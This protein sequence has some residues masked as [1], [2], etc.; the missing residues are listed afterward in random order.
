MCINNRL[1]KTLF[2]LLL[3][4]IYMEAFAQ[5][6]RMLFTLDRE[7][8]FKPAPDEFERIAVALNESLFMQI[9][10]SGE[11]LRLP[12]GESEV[13][14]RVLGVQEYFPGV[15]SFF[16]EDVYQQGRF[17]AL[18]YTSDSFSGVMQLL[19]ESEIYHF[20]GNSDSG[21]GIMARM[22]PDALD[23]LYC[24]DEQD[25]RSIHSILHSQHHGMSKSNGGLVESPQLF[26]S[27]GESNVV[28]TPDVR[29]TID[30]MIVYTPAAENWANTSG[31]VVN[32]ETAIAQAM[33]LSQQALT[34]SN[35][36]IDLRL[37]HT[38]K[39]NYDENG[40]PSGTT[41]RRLTSSPSVNL[42]NDFQGYMDEV[43][44][45]RDQYGAD[46]VAMLS[47]I[48]DTGGIA[49]RIGAYGGSSHLGFSVNR[50]Q[51]THRTYTL[52]HEIGHN[53]GLSHGRNQNQAA[54]VNFGGIHDYSTG[55][56]FSNVFNQFYNTVM[57]YT[58]SNSTDY[59]GFSDPSATFD[60]GATGEANFT[61]FGP[62]NNARS[63]R[64]MK[65]QIARYR[66]PQV[67]PPV[68]GV[69][70]QQLSATVPRGQTGSITLNISNTGAGDLVWSAETAPMPVLTKAIDNE[71]LMNLP[72]GEVIYQT[73]F[74]SSEGFTVGYSDM[75]RSWRTFNSNHRFQISN[76]N[77][78]SGSQHLR[79]PPQIASIEVNTGITAETPLLDR[80]QVGAYSVTFDISTNQSGTSLYWIYFQDASRGAVAG[81]VT[82]QQGRVFV[83][84][85]NAEGQ[86]VYTSPTGYTLPANT[87]RKI[88][89]ISNIETGKISYQLDNLPPFE[90]NIYGGVAVDFFTVSKRYTGSET[91]Y[92][93]IDNLKITRHFS[94][95]SWLDFTATS[96]HVTPSSSSNLEIVF[97]ARDKA[98]GEY[99]GTVLIRTNDANNSLIQVPVRLTVVDG[100]GIE[101]ID[102]LP[103]ATSLDQNYPNPFNPSTVIRYQLAEPGLTRLAVYDL[104][105]RQIALLI[106][107][108]RPA[109]SHEVI[110][111]AESLSSGVYLYRLET[112]NGAISRKMILTK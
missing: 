60:G 29:Q 35:V 74:E 44:T 3:S 24:G 77:P 16:A 92:L 98:I 63:I 4:F 2:V 80:G 14:F 36:G 59:P 32:L 70:T 100:T 58:V 101:T 65:G 1:F 108:D 43:H 22:R 90:T 20:T 11:I 86:L 5:Q 26:S 91:D 111:N 93:D 48:E 87:Y 67:N 34:Q 62:A 56:L 99:S 73:D 52:I 37:V 112:P 79:M 88:T 33:N 61:Q 94:G 25:E 78:A 47:F 8:A 82:V 46:L 57:N 54:A 96:G 27:A 76:A 71:S 30:V 23:Q 18:T 103:V 109:G 42:G 104:L 97:D 64:D 15:F 75:M 40:V 7:V 21:P 41:L 13:D 72:E 84:N 55:W 102:D 68:A 50:I 110:F 39:V 105:G 45:L 66:L 10:E 31:Q 38:Y 12:V 81:E 107:E 95:Y 53:M 49:W 51:Q 17:L 85:R 6:E 89:F 9:P 106:N 19:P 83:R 28:S 69:P